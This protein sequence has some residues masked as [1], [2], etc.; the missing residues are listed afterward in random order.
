MVDPEQA[1]HASKDGKGPPWMR[2][3]CVEDALAHVVVS[4]AVRNLE[5]C[6]HL[7]ILPVGVKALLIV[8]HNEP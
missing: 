3:Y 1:H 8:D 7:K 2:Q 6:V 5:D 4:R